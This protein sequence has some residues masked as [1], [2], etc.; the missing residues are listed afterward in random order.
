MGGLATVSVTGAV[1]G[2]VPAAAE[3]MGLTNGDGVHNQPVAAGS[4]G[5]G[6]VRYRDAGAG[7]RYRLRRGHGAAGL[8][9]ESQ[10]IGRHGDERAG[11]DGQGYPNTQRGEARA[12]AVDQNGAAIDADRQRRRLHADSQGGGCDAGSGSDDQPV[13]TGGGAGGNGE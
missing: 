4:R 3:W 7:G 11:A 1:R 2:A 10:A 5:G 8:V 6:H 12:D 13:A 9:I